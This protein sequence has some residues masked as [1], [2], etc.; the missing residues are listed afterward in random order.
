[1]IGK[2][3]ASIMKEIN[4]DEMR[5]RLI[6][7]TEFL[8]KLCDENGLTLYMSGGTLLGAVRHKGF[9]PWDDD[10]DVYL[11]RPDYDK[12]IEI[13]RQNGN[14]GKFKLLSHELDDNYLYT[15]AKLIDTDTL[16][17]EAGGDAGT[18]MG[19]FVDVFPIDGLGSDIKTAKK[20]MRKCNKYITLNLSLLVK[21]WR[22]NVSFFKNFAIACLRVLAKMYGANKL[23]KKL[24]ALV[25]SLPYEESK[26]VGEIIDEIGD[27]R[28]MLKSEMYEEYE[29]LDFEY[30]KFKAPKNWDKWLTQFY[31]DYMQLPPVEKQVLTHGY[32]LYRK[33]CE[34]TK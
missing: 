27:K 8:D 19:L 5:E 21:S 34:E 12:L 2:R 32:Q 28:I 3:I 24:Y 7:M 14:D 1:F 13:F 10:I 11:A 31:G 25:R 22:K 23:H 9:I 6:A 26:Y 16:L 18:E 4:I 17:I 15:F 33:T 29:L 30:T 20:H